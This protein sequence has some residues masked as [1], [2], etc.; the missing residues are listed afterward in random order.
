MHP[1]QA[2]ITF[3]LFLATVIVLLTAFQASTEVI[4]DLDVL[5]EPVYYE[6]KKRRL[7]EAMV[8][9]VEKMEKKGI[10]GLVARFLLKNA[11]EYLKFNIWGAAALESSRAYRILKSSRTTSE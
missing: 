5:A 8:E 7:V 10:R 2:A 1:L 4:P 11:R 6:G 3:L 9:E